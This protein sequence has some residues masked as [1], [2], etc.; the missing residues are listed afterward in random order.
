MTRYVKGDN[1]STDTGEGKEHEWDIETK[2]VLQSG[3]AKDLSFRVRQAF[4]RASSNVT[5]D[6]N[7]FRVIVEYPLSIL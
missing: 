7:D 1:I 2:Y 3:P 6:V 4:Y 5:G